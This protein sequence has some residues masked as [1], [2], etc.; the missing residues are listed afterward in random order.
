MGG[1][2]MRRKFF[3]VRMTWQRH[4]FLQLD[5]AGESMKI[6]TEIRKKVK[7]P[8]RIL[9]ARRKKKEEGD[10]NAKEKKKK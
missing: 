4:S 9:K 10:D 3:F 7:I 8:Y 2:K 5:I 1:S 6:Y